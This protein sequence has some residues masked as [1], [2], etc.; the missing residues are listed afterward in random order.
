MQINKR[1]RF[2]LNSVLSANVSFQDFRE[3]MISMKS[4]TKTVVAQDRPCRTGT[5]LRHALA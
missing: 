3:N 5:K 4:G 1:L 2:E